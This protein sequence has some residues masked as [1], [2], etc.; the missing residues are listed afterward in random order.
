VTDVFFN[1]RLI[2]DLI[3]CVAYIR[4]GQIIVLQCHLNHVTNWA[5]TH[6]TCQSQFQLTLT[7][8]E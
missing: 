5:V 6:F 3:S 4:E 7:L 1:R 8:Y 2:F